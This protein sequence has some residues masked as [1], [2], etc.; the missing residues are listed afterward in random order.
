MCAY[1]HRG[2]NVLN[3]KTM[4]TLFPSDKTFWLMFEQRYAPHP[5]K[6]WNA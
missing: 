2:N 5:L 1:I 6:I 3:R 4:M